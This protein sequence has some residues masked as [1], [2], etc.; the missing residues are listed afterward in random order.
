MK[1]SGMV[2]CGCQ[3][4]CSWVMSLEELKPRGCSFARNAGELKRRVFA[5]LL[6]QES[7]GSGP[8]P[9]EKAMAAM[10]RHYPV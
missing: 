7:G 8:L 4:L 10:E 1:I 5:K 9:L 3:S 6:E 2:T